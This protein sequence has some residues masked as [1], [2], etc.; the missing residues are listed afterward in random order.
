MT[1]RNRNSIPTLDRI[2][3]LHIPGPVTVNNFGEPV[4]GTPV[5]V[6][7]WG[8]RRDLTASE[9]IEFEDG[10]SVG[11]QNARIIIRHR[12]DVAIDQQLTDDVGAK[13]K[14]IGLAELGRLRH[15]ELLAEVIR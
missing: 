15:I 9:Q 7:V 12:T 2:I 1:T 4:P 3:I 13:R 14:I 11:V 6:K 8:R 5:D 10:Q